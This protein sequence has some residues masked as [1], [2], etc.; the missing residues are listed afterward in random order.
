MPYALRPL[1][2]FSSAA[3]R[4]MGEVGAERLGILAVTPES[5]GK[6]TRRKSVEEKVIPIKEWSGY[7][8]GVKNGYVFFS[9]DDGLNNGMPFAVY[10]ARTAKK[11]FEDNV[12]AEITFT[13]TT[14]Q[15]ISMQYTR[16][17]SDD[18]Q[19]LKDTSCWQRMAEKYGLGKTAA[20]DC[21]KG[22]D[23]SAESMAKGRCSDK[24]ARAMAGCVEKERPLAVKQANDAPSVISYPVQVTLNPA[25]TVNP[26]EGEIKCWPA[27]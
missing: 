26:V 7:F 3:M 10:D 24:P 21:R 5:T 15:T 20:P 12:R 16:V 13:P 22:Y 4:N 9:A 1:F 17:V 23:A 8:M 6:C 11:L 18:C 2:I 25:A 19:I 14:D 27:D